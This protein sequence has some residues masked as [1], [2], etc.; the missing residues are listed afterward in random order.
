MHRKYREIKKEKKHIH[1]QT[2]VPQRKQTGGWV[3][4]LNDE[5]PTLSSLY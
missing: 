2:E 4:K 5:S 3:L 1:D